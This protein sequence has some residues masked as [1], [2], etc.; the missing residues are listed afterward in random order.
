MGMVVPARRPELSPIKR[1]QILAGA[2]AAFNEHGYERASVDLIAARAGVS[3]ATVY[4]HFEDKKALFIACFSEEADVLREELRRSLDRAEGDI[5][6]A[7]QRVGERLLRLMLLPENVCLYRH[8]TAEAAR[9]PE[10]GRTFFARGP[11]VVYAAIAD[12]LLRW[13]EQGAI[14]LDDARAAAVQFTTLCHGELVVRAHLGMVERPADADV[15]ETV[16]RAV[17]T[18]LRAYAP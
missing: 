2:R 17:R 9:F 8:T 1:R 12:W 14:A 7:L 16:R 10:V 18:F 3:K 4:N 11:D 13:E 5:A 15:R 6:A